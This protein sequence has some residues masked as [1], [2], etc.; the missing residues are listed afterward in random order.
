MNKK[1]LGKELKKL[2]IMPSVYCLDGGT[3]DEAYTVEGQGT[4]WGVFYYERGKQSV[5]KF[6]D[7]ED[8]ACRDL[9]ERLRADPSCY[10]SAVSKQPKWLRDTYK[11]NAEE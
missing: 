3:P 7:S 10:L 4:S 5:V 1:Q 11:R 9:L 2:G 6:F 8:E